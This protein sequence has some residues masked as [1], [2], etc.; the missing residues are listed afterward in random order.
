MIKNKPLKVFYLV[1]ISKP[2]AASD[3]L[4]ISFTGFSGQMEITLEDSI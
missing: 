4:C 3:S 1:A 2:D